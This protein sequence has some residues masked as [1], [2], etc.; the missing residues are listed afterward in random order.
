MF[1][2][3][4]DEYSFSLK[5]KNIAFDRLIPDNA[6]N[7]DVIKIMFPDLV[8]SNMVLVDV[9]NNAK[10]WWNAPYKTYKKGDE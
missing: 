10:S 9:L 5:Y 7:G 6:T 2:D 1:T 8:N 3:F 4:D